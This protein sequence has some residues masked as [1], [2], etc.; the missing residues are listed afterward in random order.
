MLTNK[1]NLHRNFLND[2]LLMKDTRGAFLAQIDPF[3][4]ILRAQEECTDNNN[5]K[6]TL[7]I[8]FSFYNLQF[9]PKYSGDC[10]TYIQSGDC[11]TY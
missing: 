1:N 8:C 3:L 6:V 9:I 7:P 4:N 5:N 10:S 2:K 11:S